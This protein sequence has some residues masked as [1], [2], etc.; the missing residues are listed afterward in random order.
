MAFNWKKKLDESREAAGAVF[1]KA[2]QKT[3]EVAQDVAAVAGALNDRLEDGKNAVLIKAEEK[4]L[5]RRK[6]SEP[7]ADTPKQG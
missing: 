4:L 5:P 2:A 1:K 6:K 3:G 7:K